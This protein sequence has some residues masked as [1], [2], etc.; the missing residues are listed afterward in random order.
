M[1]DCVKENGL[2]SFEG[3]TMAKKITITQLKKELKTKTNEELV[4]IITDL[5]KALPAVKD[6]MTLKYAPESTQE[7][8][9]EAKKKVRAEFFPARGYGEGKISVAKK[10]ISEFKK[11]SINSEP[12]IDIM[13][14]YVEVCNEYTEAYG[15]IDAQFYY[16]AESMYD[17][18]VQ[19]I[20]QNDKLVYQKFADRLVELAT[21]ACVAWGFRGSLYESFATIIWLNDEEKT[22]MW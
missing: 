9:D 13:L 1:R 12:L 15:D 16:S 7:L 19:L 17:K 11:I 18:V 20:N 5:T 22:D 21:Y 8:V 2:L 10:I 3:D 14:Y 4:D 6:Y